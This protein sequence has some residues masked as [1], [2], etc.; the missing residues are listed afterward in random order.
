MNI[1]I[2]DTKNSGDWRFPVIV[3]SGIWETQCT[4][5]TQFFPSIISSFLPLFPL[6]FTSLMSLSNTTLMKKAS[7]ITTRKKILQKVTFYLVKT[8]Y[9]II[10][11]L[12]KR[13]IGMAAIA[14]NE[15]SFFCKSPLYFKM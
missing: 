9:D 6:S 13:G 2:L 14:K 15:Q 11:E 7:Y 3:P 4:C 1:Q 10:A 12:N 8:S 5:L